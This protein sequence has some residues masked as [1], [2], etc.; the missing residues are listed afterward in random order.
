MGLALRIYAIQR[1][2][3]GTEAS[4]PDQVSSPGYR[5]LPAEGTRAHTQ[6][7]EATTRIT[8][9]LCRAYQTVSEPSDIKLKA[10][11]DV[12]WTVLLEQL[13][14]Q[15]HMVSRSNQRTIHT[16]K[17]RK[18]RWWVLL[19]E[20]PLAPSSSNRF[21][22]SNTSLH[23]SLARLSKGKQRI[24]ANVLHNWLKFPLRLRRSKLKRVLRRRPLFRHV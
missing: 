13:R 4:I 11:V 7:S 22:S 15:S 9:T 2:V 17:S 19:L 21:L 6:A 23:G 12:C 8:R 18:K 5:E 10:L 1:G 3:E 16:L 20:Q 14:S 24:G